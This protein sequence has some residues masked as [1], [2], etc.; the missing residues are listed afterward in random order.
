MSHTWWLPNLI[1]GQKLFNGKPDQIKEWSEAFTVRNTGTF[2]YI[3]WKSHRQRVQG[4]NDYQ[5]FTEAR[6]HLI[7]N[8]RRFLDEEFEREVLIGSEQDQINNIAED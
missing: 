8:W 6:E 4:S 5:N 3:S 2:Y 1:K 7:L